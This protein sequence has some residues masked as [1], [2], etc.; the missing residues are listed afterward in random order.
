MYKTWH[1][2]CRQYGELVHIKFWQKT[3]ASGK[4]D[5]TVYSRTVDICLNFEQDKQFGH[6]IHGSDFAGDMD[7]YCSTTD[8]S[9]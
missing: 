7:K 9:C 5:F 4:L 6:R 2:L 8:N 3:L 1:L